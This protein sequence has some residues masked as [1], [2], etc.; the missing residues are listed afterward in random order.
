L[1]RDKA[2]ELARAKIDIG[3]RGGRPGMSAMGNNCYFIFKFYFYCIAGGMGPQ[4]TKYE[5]AAVS[6][7][8]DKPKSTYNEPA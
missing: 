5:P 2:K 8:V 1:A 4:D 3:K 6:T 7:M